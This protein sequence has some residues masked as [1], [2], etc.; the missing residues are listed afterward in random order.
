[1]IKY[2]I[3]KTN[4]LPVIKEVDA[5]KLHEDM[6]DVLGNDYET[7]TSFPANKG[8]IYYLGSVK[9]N[10]NF[11]NR[12]LHLW[13]NFESV[14]GYIPNETFVVC[15]ING[16]SLTDSETKLIMKTFGQK[17]IDYAKELFN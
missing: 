6:C 3:I 16:G 13:N 2:I 15:R 12:A 14:G 10:S 9:K 8:D 17:S 4:C 7:I 11:P 5:E 1:M